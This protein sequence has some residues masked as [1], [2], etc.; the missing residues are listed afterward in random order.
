MVGPALNT[1]PPAV[2]LLP[3]PPAAW[4]AYYIND[5]RFESTAAAHASAAL[6]AD[7]A[8]GAGLEET[9]ASTG[10]SVQQTA[11]FMCPGTA[12][13]RACRIAVCIADIQTCRTAA[14]HILRPL[15]ARCPSCMHS[16]PTAFSSNLLSAPATVILAVKVGRVLYERPTAPSPQVPASRVCSTPDDSHWTGA[17]GGASPGGD[18]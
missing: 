10:T 12:P 3:P 13:R 9:T 2:G 18:S 11:V 6:A 16:S 17:P 4:A 7:V 14:D 1:S 8:P 5:V 15:D